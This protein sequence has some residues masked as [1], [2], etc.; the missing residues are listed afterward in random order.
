MAKR[1]MVGW[2]PLAVENTDAPVATA[3]SA[4]VE[5]EH[6]APAPASNSQ[7]PAAASVSEPV[8]AAPAATEAAPSAEAAPVADGPVQDPNLPRRRMAG[9]QPLAVANTAAPVASVPAAQTAP[10]APEPAASANAEPAAPTVEAT[11]APAQPAAPAGPIQDPDVPRRRMAG[12]Q[13][14]AVAHDAPVA[15]PAGARSEERRVGKEGGGRC[16]TSQSQTIRRD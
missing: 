6:T 14:L 16:R 9:W 2:Q 3:S 8:T 5:P 10:A 1:R 15:A 4:A 11:A 7:Q 12:W 13:P